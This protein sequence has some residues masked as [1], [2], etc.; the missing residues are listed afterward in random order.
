MTLVL[1]PSYYEPQNL[2]INIVITL[3]GVPFYYLCVRW[4]NK[5]KQY[6][7]AS[8]GVEKFCQILFQSVFIDDEEEEKDDDKLK[9]K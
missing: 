7:L 1:V 9:E 2:G 3:S 8:K 5:P 4:K 6:K